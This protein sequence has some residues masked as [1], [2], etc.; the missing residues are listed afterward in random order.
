[1]R[2]QFRAWAEGMAPESPAP[3]NQASASL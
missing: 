2:N 3:G 1:M